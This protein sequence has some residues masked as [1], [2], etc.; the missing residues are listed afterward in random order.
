MSEASTVEKN[1]ENNIEE[2]V[3]GVEKKRIMIV[4]DHRSYAEMIAQVI[5]NEDD[6]EACAITSGI[7]D[8]LP[9]IQKTNP[10]VII[11][12]LSLKNKESGI[13]LISEIRK[14]Y[15]DIMI[16]VLTMHYELHYFKESIKAGANGYALKV[17]S[18]VNI[19][20]AIRKVLNGSM[21]ISDEIKDAYCKESLIGNKDEYKTSI[22]SLSPREREVLDYIADGLKTNRIAEILDISAGTISTYI[23]RIKIKLNIKN[24]HDLILFA[25][26]HLKK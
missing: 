26:E 19:I 5:N 3:I 25:V 2:E 15:N 12:D 13:S 9:I 11:V 18:I 20:S 17:E 24:M 22:D 14:Y 10:D 8:S 23:K 1:I 16:L 7:A 6:L 4:E 21:Y